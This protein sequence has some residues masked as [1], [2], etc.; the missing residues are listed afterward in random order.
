MSAWFG[1]L[2]D[3]KFDGTADD[4]RMAL[5]EVRPSYIVYW[6]STVSSLG[7]VKEVG[8]AAFTGK[9]ANTGVLRELLSEDIEAA[10][11]S[12]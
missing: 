12:A 9:V 3:G 8:V 6:K 1:D 10:R 7:F 4:P 2:K 5:I 11:A